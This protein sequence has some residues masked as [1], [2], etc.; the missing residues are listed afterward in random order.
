MKQAFIEWN[1]NSLSSELLEIANQILDIYSEQGYT[2]TLRQLYYQFVS[3][4]LL[5]QEWADKETGSTNNERSYKNLGN[6]ISKG[7]LAGFID[8]DLIEDRGRNAKS[9]T[10]W[11]SPQQILQTA[12]NGYYIDHWDGQEY[13]IEVAVE[14][15]AVSNIVEPICRKWDVT[16][17]A[18][19]GYS[20][21]SAMYETSQRFLEHIENGRETVIIYLG[22][23]DPSGIDM[24]RDIEDRMRLFLGLGQQYFDVDRIALNL[25]QVRQYN[26]PENPAKI[27]DSRAKSY[28]SQFGKSSW[29]LDALEPSVLSDVVEQAILNYLNTSLWQ[30]IDEGQKKTQQKIKAFAKNFTL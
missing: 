16:F 17:M 21:Q 2:L 4:D 27:T 5:P 30:K 19:K 23:H 15:D 20:S 24:S 13:Y 3:R 18:N 1:P 29:E 9:N 10:H 7:R 26:P 12:A 11:E 28:I 6:L 8:W 25:N 14:K 22:D